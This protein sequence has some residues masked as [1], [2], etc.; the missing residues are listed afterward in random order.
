MSNA[1][2][3]PPVVTGKRKRPAVSYVE[4]NAL[5]DDVLSNAKSDKDEDSDDQSDDDGTFGSRRKVRFR[6]LDCR[7]PDIMT[8]NSQ[9]AH[10]ENISEEEEQE[11]LDTEEGKAFSLS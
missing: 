11:E 1:L 6:V 4:S 10:Q 8:N 3:S 5:L 9:T 7:T 2:G